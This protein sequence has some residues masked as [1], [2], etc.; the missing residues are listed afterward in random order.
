MLNASANRLHLRLH[1][2]GRRVVS[3]GMGG[4]AAPLEAALTLE[5]K[6]VEGAL[7]LVPLLF[8]G[9]PVAQSV[10]AVTAC[11][12]ALGISPGRNRQA[13]RRIL[14]A[15]EIL[16]QHLSQL[17][18]GWPQR[19]HERVQ[20]LS[21]AGLRGHVQ[22]LRDCV[23]PLE[24]W[25]RLEGKEPYIDLP[26]LRDHLA[27]LESQLEKALYGQPAARWLELPDFAALRRWAL[28]TDT[29]LARTV[30]AL[31]DLHLAAVG[32]GDSEPL[33]G[34][35]TARLGAAMGDD[36]FLRHPQ[37]EDAPRES[38]P[39]A[40]LRRHPLV[41]VVREECGNGLLTRITARMA[42]LPLLLRGLEH[43]ADPGKALAVNGVV[44]GELLTPG[45]GEGVGVVE[46][47]V[48]RL[49]H[50]VEIH[51]G[52]V[53]RWRILHPER[54]NLHPRGPLAQGLAGLEAR[55]TK[56]LARNA[57]LLVASLLPHLKHDLVIEEALPP[58]LP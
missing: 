49:A 35:D 7:N 52:R 15:A 4:G 25:R 38:G 9:H 18:L 3:V 8:S 23:T 45:L 5:G 6:K 42:E 43:L 37:W 32:G 14:L 54:W 50:R 16:Q 20:P 55:D 46:S 12:E 21:L 39:L 27:A 48:G 31:L 17:T 19:L 26:A 51:K 47:A 44:E 30:D 41:G 28:T 1:W 22:G 56:E 29:P 24:E 40:R 2:D 11:E 58:L 33:N 36:D 10:A 34:V 13:A 57:E 53:R